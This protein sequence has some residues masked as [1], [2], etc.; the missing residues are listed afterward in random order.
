MSAV[1][2]WR[3]LRQMERDD[4]QARGERNRERLK[5]LERDGV[6]CVRWFN[7]GRHARVWP[8]AGGQMVDFYPTTERVMVRG[9]R[10][11]QGWAKLLEALGLPTEGTI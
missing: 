10:Y 5:R 7:K 8:A 2:G 6:I 9:R 1:D 4:R 11:G 3:A